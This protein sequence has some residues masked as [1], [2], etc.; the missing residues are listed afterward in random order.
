MP[1]T[2]PIIEAR[3]KLTTL[4]E[5]LESSPDTG[6]VEITRRGRPVL[7]LMSWDLYESLLETMEILGD[8]EMRRLFR[9]G[10][11]EVKAGK[12]VPWQ[13]ARKSLAP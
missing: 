13:K 1:R 8:E 3:K 6:A 2:M 10:V 5:L 9:Q 4:P 11:R 12:G 7:A